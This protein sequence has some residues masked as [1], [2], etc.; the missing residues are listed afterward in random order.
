MKRHNV[1]LTININ[2]D[3]WDHTTRENY[4]WDNVNDWNLNNSNVSSSVT[5]NVN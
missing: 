3:Q 2:Q 5:V 4:T 1:Y